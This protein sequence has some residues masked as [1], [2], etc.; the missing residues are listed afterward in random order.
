MT[1]LRGRDIQVDGDDDDHG[2]DRRHNH[3]GECDP[4]LRTVSTNVTHPIDNE[5]R[6]KGAYR[7]M[8]ALPTL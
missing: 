7:H 1:A 5:H 3:D 8:W 4:E 6:H 2:H